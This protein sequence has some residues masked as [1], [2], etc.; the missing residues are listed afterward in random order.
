M[1]TIKIK[2]ILSAIFVVTLF[3]ACSKDDVSTV[4]TVNIAFADKPS[5][6]V[7]QIFTIENE[8]TAIYSKQL[9]GK[10]SV[11]V[12]LN[13]GN[14]VIRPYALSLGSTLFT[15]VSF[16]ITP[17]KNVNVSYNSNHIGSIVK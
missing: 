13:V 16:Q 3:A 12:E 7:V 15:S 10:K 5:D 2:T 6:L 8:R 14:Y 4:G 1:K 9:I 11:S 17:N